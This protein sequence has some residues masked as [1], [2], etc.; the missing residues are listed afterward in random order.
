MKTQRGLTLLELMISMLVGLIVIGTTLVIY[1]S[2]IT[3]NSDITRATRL[4]HDLDSV[5]SL[6]INDIRRA[7]FWFGA[8]AQANTLNNPFATPANNINIVNFSG[9]SDCILY[10]Y[11]ISNTDDD[12][13]PDQFKFNFFGFRL[14]G[15]RI[16]MRLSG[17]N[18][19]DCSNGSDAWESFTLNTGHEQINITELT[20]SFEETGQLAAT[21][22]CRNK[23]DPTSSTDNIDCTT[24]STGDQLVQ[25]RLVNIVLTGTFGD[26]ATVTKTLR[27]STQVRNDR[28]YVF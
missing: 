1:Q 18:S 27:A 24:P 3:A 22:R 17:E 20:F 25:R 9:T 28:L 7:G 14:N 6:M 13:D 5:M 15:D 21:S 11:D 16:Q 8:T 19:T 23:T 26:D 10:S 2:T 12:T 4:N